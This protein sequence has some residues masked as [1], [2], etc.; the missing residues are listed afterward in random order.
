VRRIPCLNRASP[1]QCT[2]HVPNDHRS[3]CT[4][5]E[6][7]V[8][9]PLSRLSGFADF[10]SITYQQSS[11]V[12][13][14]ASGMAVRQ[15]VPRLR[16]AMGQDGLHNSAMNPT[17]KLYRDSRRAAAWGIALGLGLGLAKFVGGFF[18]RSLALV[19]DAVHS[20]VDA[21]ISAALVGALL[22]AERP[23]DSEHPY[24]HGRLE[25]VVGAGVA[26]VLLCLA[27]G[28]A[29]EA[30]VTIHE[31]HRPPQ[32]YTL[33]IAVGGALFQEW[34]YRYR[35]RVARRVGSGALMATAWDYRLD[36]LGALAVVVGVSLSKWSGPWWQWADRAAAL[37]IAATVL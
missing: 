5:N 22:I 27:A 8:M 35:S 37:A 12:W 34:F 26:L 17:A 11:T 10:L 25:A 28:I 32:T 4:R 24:R 18:G 33:L 20:L 9:G 21:A 31:P 16:G 1:P 19:S 3:Q 7:T 2:R 30:I 6:A 36:A 29:W 13:R 14:D 15:Q 23:A